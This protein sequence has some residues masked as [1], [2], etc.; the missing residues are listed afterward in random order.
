M[1]RRLADRLSEHRRG[2]PPLPGPLSPHQVPP[3]LGNPMAIHMGMGMAM[4]APPPPPVPMLRPPLAEDDLYSNAASIPRSERVVPGRVSRRYED[5]AEVH[6]PRSRRSREEPKGSA[7]AG[8]NGRGRGMNRVFEWRGY[9]EPGVP[10]G[11]ATST[12]GS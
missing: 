10:E 11:E 4:P 6:A 12:V 9:V 1:E 2:M 5:E 3:L 7:M 8:L